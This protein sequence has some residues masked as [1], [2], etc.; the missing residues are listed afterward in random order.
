MVAE[1]KGKIEKKLG[2]GK[3]G[4]GKRNEAL[5][6]GKVKR[7]KRGLKERE[8]KISAEQKVKVKRY[9]VLKRKGN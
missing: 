5:K 4:K 2:A 3:K 7:R 8:N 6:K 1:K 9:W